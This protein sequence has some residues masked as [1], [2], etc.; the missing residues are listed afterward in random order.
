MAH[1]ARAS[2]NPSGALAGSRPT[3]KRESGLAGTWQ[4]DEVQALEAGVN[5]YGEGHWKEILDDDVYSKS[6]K[7]RTNTDLKDKWRIIKKHRDSR[8]EKDSKGTEEQRQHQDTGSLASPS[9]G[10][11][12]SSRTWWRRT[13]RVVK[14][15][16]PL[17][18]ENPDL[19]MK[20]TL[21]ALQELYGKVFGYSVKLKDKET[22]VKRLREAWESVQPKPTAAAKDNG[23]ATNPTG[24]SG[25]QGGF[26][27]M[28][29]QPNPYAMFPGMYMHHPSMSFSPQQM[30]AQQAAMQ[31]A[32]QQAATQQMMQHM[33]S[34]QAMAQH[35]AAAYFQATNGM[36]S[37]TSGPGSCSYPLSIGTY[38]WHMSS[39]IGSGQTPSTSGFNQGGS[40]AFAKPSATVVDGSTEGRKRKRNEQQDTPEGTLPASDDSSGNVPA[41][42]LNVAS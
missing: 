11:D 9:N 25:T 35:A 30:M 2:G 19:L 22:Y 7:K 33:A 28:A 10:S 17:L 13:P 3:K 14:D 20:K 27:G 38:P 32:L 42:E 15:P 5:K 26:H 29:G 16:A 23:Y 12:V 36:P 40:S 24:L 41:H 21:A 39:D 37:T 1:V 31:A 6:L 18:R 34:H 8:N 4:A